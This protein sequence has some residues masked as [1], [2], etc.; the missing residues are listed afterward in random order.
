M[1]LQVHWSCF[2]C[3]WIILHRYQGTMRIRVIGWARDMFK[4][5]SHALN[6]LIDTVSHPAWIDGFG[7]LI[8]S[9]EQEAKRCYCC[10]WCIPSKTPKQW[11]QCLVK[12]CQRVK[13]IL[14]L[15][16]FSSVCN[17]RPSTYLDLDHFCDSLVQAAEAGSRPSHWP[18]RESEW[19]REKGVN[20][21][22]ILHFFALWLND[23][24][25]GFWQTY[26]WYHRHMWRKHHLARAS[27]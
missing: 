12:E 17:S 19:M 4:H 20:L 23:L 15:Q 9:Q 3:I 22:Q 18:A 16:V 6:Q 11:K 7:G 24:W 25:N 5:H 14:K 21:E 26:I 2:T 27:G 8:L 13:N 10:A 1:L